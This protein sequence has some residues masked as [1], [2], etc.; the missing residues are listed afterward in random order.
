MLHHY[1]NGATTC[2]TAETD[3]TTATTSTSILR[4]SATT[5]IPTMS[6]AVTYELV[7]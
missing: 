1:W 7:L 6:A 5:A 4:V 3:G 2:T